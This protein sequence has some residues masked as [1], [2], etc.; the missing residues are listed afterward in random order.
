MT[1]AGDELCLSQAVPHPVAKLN[2][3]EIR[4]KATC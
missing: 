4:T 3:L 1:C 2:I